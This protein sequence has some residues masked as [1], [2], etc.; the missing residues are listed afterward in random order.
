[1]LTRPNRAVKIV[2]RNKGPT[3]MTETLPLSGFRAVSIATNLPGPAATHRLAKMGLSIL[4]IE[5][6]SGDALAMAGGGWYDDIKDSLDCIETL[7]LRSEEGREALGAHLRQADLLI[8]S[9]RPSALVRL[10]ISKEWLASVN[11]RLCWLEIVGDVDAPEVPGHDL[12]YQAEVGLLHGT[13]MPRTLIAD[14]AGAEDAVVQALGLLLGRERGSA[15]RHA[16]V[17]LKQ[18]AAR[19]TQP[20]QYGLTGDQG[21]L[22]GMIPQ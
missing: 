11:D 17:G 4:K 22:S 9:H 1:M 20:L 8:T 13:Q 19:F 18:A 12:T 7:N 5:P 6:P 15:T 16:V 2:V 10:G 3:T 14:L 21:P